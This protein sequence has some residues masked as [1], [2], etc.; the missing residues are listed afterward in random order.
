MLQTYSQTEITKEF[1][2]VPLCILKVLDSSCVDLFLQH[3]QERNKPPVFYRDKGYPLSED[4]ALGLATNCQDTLYVRACDYASFSRQ[5]TREMGIAFKRD[6]LPP[7]E[8]FELLQ[9]TVSLKIEQT[10]R[11]VDC[12]EYVNHA[13]TLG[14]Q[15]AALLD[16]EDVL[17]SD[18]FAIVRHDFNTFVHVTNVAAYAT[19]LAKEVGFHSALELE[20]IAVG[21]LLHDLGKRKIPNSVLNKASALTPEEWEMIQ[22]HPQLGYEDL[23][24]RENITRGQLM[25]VYQHHEQLNGSGY[26]VGI[27]GEE[28]HPWA[29]L[30]SVVDVFEALTGE[31]PYRSPFTPQQAL[32]FIEKRTGTQFDEEM[33]QCW[34]SVIQKQ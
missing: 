28:I 13:N 18:L 29:K 11:L 16:Q 2:Q 10:V 1:I 34:A 8:Q 23:C 25:M 14:K 22:Q 15:I 21:G 12:T 32:E 3:E 17:P 9:H 24:H 4:R 5:L 26:P 6:A 31:R 20:Q 19:L 7:T 33:V 27:T 30:L